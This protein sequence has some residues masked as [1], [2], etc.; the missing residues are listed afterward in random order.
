MF[1]SYEFKNFKEQIIAK[2]PQNT[3]KMENFSNTNEMCFF[4]NNPVFSKSV[5]VEKLQ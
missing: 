3:T 4:E 1:H 2:L 5:K